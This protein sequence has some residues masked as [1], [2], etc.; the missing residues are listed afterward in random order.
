MTKKDSWVRARR[1]AARDYE[2]VF[3]WDELADGTPIVVAV[4]P[5]LPGCMA[6]G[7][8][9]EEAVKE[10]EEAKSVYI[11]S[12]LEDCQP[13]PEPKS[14]KVPDEA[15]QQYTWSLHE[16]ASSLPESS[17]EW[18]FTVRPLKNRNW[19][20]TKSVTGDSTQIVIEGSP[21]AVPA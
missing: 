14:Q 3:E 16:T 1:F 4:T 10:L 20:T 5:E 11:W 19:E 12:L 9:K 6:Q 15:G 18:L 7:A 17:A 13:V 2:V 8:T 21:L